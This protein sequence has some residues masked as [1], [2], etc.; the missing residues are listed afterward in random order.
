MEKSLKKRK[1]V[2]YRRLRKRFDLKEVLPKAKFGE[3]LKKTELIFF[4]DKYD[5]LNNYGDF[6]L[7]TDEQELSMALETAERLLN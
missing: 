4:H 7:L 5:D 6:R 3:K 2:Q 1:E